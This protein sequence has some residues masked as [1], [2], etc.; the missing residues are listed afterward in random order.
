MIFKPTLRIRGTRTDVQKSV[1]LPR[2]SW[3]WEL[4]VMHLL[5]SSSPSVSSH[6]SESWLLTWKDWWS[7]PSSKRMCRVEWV[8]AFFLRPVFGGWMAGRRPYFCLKRKWRQRHYWEA[9]VIFPKNISWEDLLFTAN[10]S[11]PKTGWEIFQGIRIHYLKQ[12]WFC[13]WRKLESTKRTGRV[14]APRAYIQPC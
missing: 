11:S 14:G 13:V 7:V 6:D 1:G 2:V 8:N 5:G 9:L 12:E 4:G 10:P 3:L